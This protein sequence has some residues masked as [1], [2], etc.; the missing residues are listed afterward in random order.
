MVDFEHK[1]DQSRVKK[2]FNIRT[3]TTNWTNRRK[4]SQ[5][6]EHHQRAVFA[7]LPL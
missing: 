5:N 3:I 7:L 1:N 4:E 2:T 6:A